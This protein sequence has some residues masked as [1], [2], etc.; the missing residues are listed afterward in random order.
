LRAE[1]EAGRDAP[2]PRPKPSKRRWC[3]ATI[4]GS[5]EPLRSRGCS[6]R[7]EPC[8]VWI[9]FSLKPLR[10]MPVPPG[11]AP[12]L[13]AEMLAQLGRH[14]PLDQPLGQPLQ[15]PVGFANSSA[16]SLGLSGSLGSALLP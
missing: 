14:R 7:T 8:P 5:N 12:V 10:A 2:R 13:V 16:S 1:D 9:V 11:G 15:Q 6:I 3:F 4:C